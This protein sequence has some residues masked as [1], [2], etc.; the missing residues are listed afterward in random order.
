MEIDAD[1]AEARGED[2]CGEVGDGAGGSGYGWLAIG[3]ARRRE[4]TPRQVA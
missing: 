1:A 4:I 3:R 2:Q